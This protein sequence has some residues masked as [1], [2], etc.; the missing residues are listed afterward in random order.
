MT[1][2]C[3]DDTTT[4]DPS[5][6]G[7][8]ISFEPD[9]IELKAGTTG[10]MSYSIVS[11]ENI[12]KLTIIRDGEGTILTVSDFPNKTSYAGSLSLNAAAADAGKKINYTFEVTNKDGAVAKKTIRT[13]GNRSWRWRYRSDRNQFLFCPHDGCAR[14]CFL[15]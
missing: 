5:D 6:S 12:T 7:I 13:Y 4:E 2:S 10:S 14:K 11:L 8:T 3:G 1:A 9:A 15:R